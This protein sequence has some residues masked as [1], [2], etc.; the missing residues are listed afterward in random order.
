MLLGRVTP[1]PCIVGESVVW[2]A[3]VGG[4]DHYGTWEAPL[5]VIRAPNLITRPTAQAIVEKSSAQCC[6]VSPIALAVEVP[7]PASPT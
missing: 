4:G 2:W 3:E 5:G 7:I 1:A 6:G